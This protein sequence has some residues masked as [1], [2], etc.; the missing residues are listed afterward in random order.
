[1]PP[2][3]FPPPWTVEV[4]PQSAALDCVLPT[5]RP[6]RKVQNGDKAGARHTLGLAN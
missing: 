2:R 1:M 6:C 5:E 4:T 3:R